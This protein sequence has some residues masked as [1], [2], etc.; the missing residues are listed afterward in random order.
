MCDLDMQTEK[1]GDRQTD[2]QTCRR[3]DRQTDR[4]T[5][6]QTHRQTHRQTGRQTIGIKQADGRQT[7]MQSADEAFRLVTK[8]DG[9]NLRNQS[10]PLC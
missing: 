8:S 1:Q 4:H 10:V 9:Q 7:S 5:D 3:I 2:R 6:R